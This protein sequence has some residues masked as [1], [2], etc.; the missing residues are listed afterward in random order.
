MKAQ[1]D[2]DPEAVR[3][4]CLRMEY[5]GSRVT[6][7]PPPFNTDRDVLCLVADHAVFRDFVLACGFNMGGS[8][9][10]DRSLALDGSDRF[11]S[12]TL[13]EINLIVTQ[14]ARFFDKF[15]AATS[16]AKRL[17][18]LD[19][20]DRIALFQAVLYGNGE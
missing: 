12:Y 7:N 6:C 16:V 8:E 11:S 15:M 5:V 9:L 1:Q 4:Q 20:N 17:N 3:S 13:D 18:L 10:L 2:F 14:D 19:K